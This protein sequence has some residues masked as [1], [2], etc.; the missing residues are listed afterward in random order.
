MINSN[1]EAD[2]QES[3]F[4]NNGAKKRTRGRLFS[5]GNNYASLRMMKTGKGK[6]NIL[7]SYIKQKAGNG[8]KIAAFYIGVIDSINNNDEA[9][10]CEKCTAYIYNGIRI[11]DDVAKE[12]HSWLMLNGLADFH[13]GASLYLKNLIQA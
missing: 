8:K 6:A 10:A 11:N 5:K 7:E 4:K 3:Q 1:T 13:Q 12:A 9:V 2:V